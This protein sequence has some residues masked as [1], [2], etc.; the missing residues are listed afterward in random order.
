MSNHRWFDDRER[1]AIPIQEPFEFEHV[2]YL[3][4]P[5]VIE[6]DSDAAWAQWD[7]AVQIGNFPCNLNR[8]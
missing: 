5:D 2:S 6:S 7:A 1:P 3:P 8:D 4:A